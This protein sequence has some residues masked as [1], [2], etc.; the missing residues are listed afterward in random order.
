MLAGWIGGG[1]VDSIPVP[2][3]GTLQGVEGCMWR[4][5]WVADAAAERIGARIVRVEVFEGRNRLLAIDVL[6]HV[7]TRADVEGKR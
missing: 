3:E 6:K 5:N 2:S 7:R 1:D 4:T